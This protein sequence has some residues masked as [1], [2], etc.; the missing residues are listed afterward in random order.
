MKNA[1]FIATI[2]LCLPTLSLADS[3]SDA[4]KAAK[5]GHKGSRSVQTEPAEENEA[6]EPVDNSP[7]I[8]PKNSM[9]GGRT[10]GLSYSFHQILA[11]QYDEG[12]Y[13]GVDVAW[14]TSDLV[15]GAEISLGS[16]SLDPDGNLAPSIKGNM[17]RA[18][19][20]VFGANPL[21]TLGPSAL[22]QKYAMGLFHSSW[23]YQNPIYVDNK[24][25]TT[26]GLNALVFTA[27]LGYGLNTFHPG[28][29]LY[30]T[31]GVGVNVFTGD[32]DAG[33]KN[34]FVDSYFFVRSQFGMHF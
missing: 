13:L 30:A 34:D 23:R 7:R 24:F 29:G 33:L 10:W 32:T 20:S 22:F 4:M 26:D 12:G 31:V 5:D 2:L 27:D 1:L 15:L 16:V 14:R 19:I 6:P 11:T 25:E 8:E 3:L 18:G 9:K 28:F 21:L 17:G